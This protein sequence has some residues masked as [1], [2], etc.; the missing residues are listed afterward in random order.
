MGHGGRITPTGPK[1]TI[2][3]ELQFV[4]ARLAK[5]GYY[6]GDLRAVREAPLRDVLAALN[7]EQFIEEYQYACKESANA[8]I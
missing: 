6:G 3:D 2:T 5:L 4:A 8:G 1:I 7:Y